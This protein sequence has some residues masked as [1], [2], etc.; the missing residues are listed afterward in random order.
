MT[1][2]TTI[3]AVFKSRKAVLEALDKLVALDLVDVN[4]AA[5]IARAPQGHTVVIDHTLTPREAGFMGGFFGALLGALSMIQLGGAL[6]LP[7]MGPLLAIIASVVLGALVGRQTGRVAVH[8][9]THNFEP[10]QIESLAKRL[11]PG[12]TALLIEIDSPQTYSNL[13]HALNSLKA[14]VIDQREQRSVIIS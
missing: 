14:E 1:E 5:V 11:K 13:Q 2:P 7:E 12:E 4:A 8:L 6:D 10:E 9:I 3:I